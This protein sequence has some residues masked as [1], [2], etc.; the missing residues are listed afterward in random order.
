MWKDDIFDLG[1]TKFCFL[2][3]VFFFQFDYC[4]QI[5]QP[6]MQVVENNLSPIFQFLKFNKGHQKHKLRINNPTN[7][8]EPDFP[9]F[10][11]QQG[12]PEAQA[13]Y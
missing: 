5:L 7:P 8:L 1:C 13:L 6:R 11:V 4:G 9:I 10:E 3:R 12:P 2:P